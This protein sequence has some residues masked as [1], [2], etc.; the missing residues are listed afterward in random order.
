MLTAQSAV[1]LAL[2][3]VAGAAT[4]YSIKWAK[5]VPLLNPNDGG[6]FDAAA[7]APTVSGSTA[8]FCI[9]G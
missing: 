2:P 6:G 1:C 7:C 3:S 5:S 9:A 8:L 4:I